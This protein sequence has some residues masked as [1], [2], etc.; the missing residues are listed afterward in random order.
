MRTCRSSCA[1]QEEVAVVYSFHEGKKL[2][3][4]I[5]HRQL[6]EKY[7]DMLDPQYKSN[8]SKQTLEASYVVFYAKDLQ[9]INKKYS[10][11]MTP[12]GEV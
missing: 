2:R 12:V 10:D 6:N 9:Y 5:T 8:L 4:P 7:A 11:L 3:F 1:D